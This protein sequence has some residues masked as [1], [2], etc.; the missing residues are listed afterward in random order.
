MKA[1]FTFYSFSKTL[2]MQS[3][4]PQANGL[5]EEHWD[6]ALQDSAGVE[7]AGA[8]PLR[9][10]LL[11]GG[12]HQ[13]LL[14]RGAHRLCGGGVGTRRYRAHLWIWLFLCDKNRGAVFTLVDYVTFT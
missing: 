11:V 1:Y 7:K 5:G 4:L 2:S 8:G 14:V 6:H 9:L 12:A 10:V 3:L 13:L